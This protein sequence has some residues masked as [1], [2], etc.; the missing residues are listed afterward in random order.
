MRVRRSI[1]P[2][3]L[4]L[5]FFVT[6]CAGPVPLTPAA[7]SSS[8]APAAPAA[9]VATGP[10]KITVAISGDPNTLSNSVARAGSGGVAGVDAV[11]QMVSAGMSL[12]DDQGVL[13]PQLGRAV[14]SIE[15]GQWKVL[16]DGRMEMAWKI[17]PNAQ[18]HDGTPVTADDLLFAVQ[19]GQDKEIPALGNAG[20][21]SID[22]VEATDPRTVVVHWKKPF[23]LADT[24]FTF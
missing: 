23:I 8:G 5:V 14:P 17:K 18:W 21:G 10:K 3:G 2:L 1:G 7:P 19:V 4:I 15:N 16:S 13:H 20:Y 22:T 24:L 12:M 6:A 11:E 9:A